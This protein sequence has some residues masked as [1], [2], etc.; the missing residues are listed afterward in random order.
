MAQ[1]ALLTLADDQPASSGYG[2]TGYLLSEHSVNLGAQHD[3]FNGQQLFAVFT[4]KTNLTFTTGTDSMLIEIKSG[5]DSTFGS[6]A[7]QEV[8]PTIGRSARLFE[9]DLAKG[10]RFVI[11]LNPITANVGNSAH[12]PLGR[13]VIYGLIRGQT[14][15]LADVNLAGGTFDLEIRTENPAGQKYYPQTNSVG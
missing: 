15:L 7:A 9:A 14:A 10:K 8:R 5:P 1:D 3:A 13:P 11:A 12:T 2:A 4:V 6:A